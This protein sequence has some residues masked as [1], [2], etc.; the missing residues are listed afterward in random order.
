MDDYGYDERT[1]LLTVVHLA[2]AAVNQA[3]VSALAVDGVGLTIAAGQL[4]VVLD[5][6]SSMTGVWVG[7]IAGQLLA[8]DPMLVGATAWTLLA[9]IGER[10]R[11][12]T[13]VGSV[14]MSL[15]IYEA[16]EL[17]ALR[18]ERLG[19]EG[20]RSGWVEGFLEGT[21][22]VPHTPR[23]Q[24]VVLPDAGPGV[25]LPVRRLCCVLNREATC[26]ACPTCPQY[27]PAQRVTET[28]SWL[29][30]LDE[31]DFEAMVGRK[32][33]GAAASGHRSSG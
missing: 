18:L 17:E 16:L 4:G 27:A 2:V 23:R 13:G 3:L 5:G 21:S 26:H 22:F 24:V 31:G 32:P 14:A 11:S 15:L 25:R 10:V 12:A 30:S 19:F 6:T 1:G 33:I 28:V 20:P 29:Q 8:A 9:P 7:R